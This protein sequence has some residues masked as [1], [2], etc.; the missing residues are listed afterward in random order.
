[1]GVSSKF[2]LVL[3][4]GLV[5]TSIASAQTGLYNSSSLGSSEP[6]TSTL[7]LQLNPFRG[8]ESSPYYSLEYTY[9]WSQMLSFQ[10]RGT[11]ASRET[12]MIGGNPFLTGGSDIEFRVLGVRE[13][14]FGSIGV[15]KPDTPAQDKV[16]GTFQIGVRSDVEEAGQFLL[17][18]S[19]VT[20]DDVTVVGFGG[21]FS[22]SLENGFGIDA[23]A[24][25][26]VKGDNTVS[27]SLGVPIRET[28]FSLG[29]SYQV[30]EQLSFR[31]G[32]GNSLGLTTGF[33][34]TP[35]LGAGGGLFF[36]AQVKF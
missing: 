25:V 12:F 28:L 31:L 26:I 6:G 20:S 30:D 21:G 1:M 36:G 23:S 7:S 15:A 3:A 16:V 22:K 11:T 34:L 24:T 4:S 5:L 29:A 19:G 10:L 9:T 2:A 13:Q 17:A 14:F 35:R 18:L 32:Y 27:T 33:A 8:N